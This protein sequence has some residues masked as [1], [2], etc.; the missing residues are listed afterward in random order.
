VLLLQQLAM[1]AAGCF[2]SAKDNAARCSWSSQPVVERR[3]VP[4]DLS[5]KAGVE[6]IDQN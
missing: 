2:G 3:T 6:S 5:L 4:S 1:T